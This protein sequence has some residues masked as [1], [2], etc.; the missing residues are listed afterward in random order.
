[1]P[2]AHPHGG[3]TI[4][5]C[6]LLVSAALGMH[7]SGTANSYDG[8]SEGAGWGLGACVCGASRLRRQSVA[9]RWARRPAPT[10]TINSQSIPAF[11]PQSSLSSSAARHLCITALLR[12]AVRPCHP[13]VCPPLLRPPAPPTSVRQL[14]VVAGLFDETTNAC[15]ID[16]IPEYFDRFYAAVDLKLVGRHTVQC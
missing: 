15:G 10:S 4:L 11:Q 13:S 2:P 12:Q 6:L 7:E 14:S 3:V 1:M 9:S 8:N 5:C 16:E